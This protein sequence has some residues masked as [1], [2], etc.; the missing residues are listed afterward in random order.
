MRKKIIF[1]II[2]IG[3][4]IL[5]IGIRWTMK[6]PKNL[7]LNRVHKE[8][9]RLRHQE[10]AKDNIENILNDLESFRFKRD[11]HF[12]DSVGWTLG[13]SWSEN[14]KV[15]WITLYDNCIEYE[16]YLYTTEYVEEYS[17]YW[18]QLLGLF[19]DKST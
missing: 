14:D 12:G 17:E 16:G 1:G 9:A 4:V 19:E 2:I 11:G 15:K 6:H 5:S 7:P 13:I 18:S 10:Q 8:S 3:L